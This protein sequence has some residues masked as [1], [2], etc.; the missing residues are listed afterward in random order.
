MTINKIT[1][2]L[3]FF[4]SLNISYGQDTVRIKKNQKLFFIVGILISKC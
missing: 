4:S 2:F 1:V 3:I